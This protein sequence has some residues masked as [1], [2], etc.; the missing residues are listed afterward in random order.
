MLRDIPGGRVPKSAT[1]SPRDESARPGPARALP[2]AESS[3]LNS[4]A[5][6]N[7]ILPTLI[8]TSS[9]T[10]KE[11]R[12]PAKRFLFRRFNLGSSEST[13][14]SRRFGLGGMGVGSSGGKQWGGQG[15]GS[16]LSQSQGQGLGQGLG[17]GPWL[18]GAS[19]GGNGGGVGGGMGLRTSASTSGSGVGTSAGSPAIPRISTISG[20]EV[21]KEKDF[22]EGRTP[23]RGFFKMFRRS[24]S[25]K[26]PEAAEGHTRSE[27]T[28]V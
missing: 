17:Q 25:E 24:A 18:G 12:D 28:A 21:T 15:L 7:P 14:G 20:G 6:S 19:G 26:P 27:T 5:A 9:P 13:P 10:I 22:K 23:G 11:E 8:A 2:L 4:R 16:S 1:R 3:S